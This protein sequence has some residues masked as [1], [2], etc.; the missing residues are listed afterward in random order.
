[1]AVSLILF[2]LAAQAADAITLVLGLPV[3]GIRAEENPLVRA[4]YA[5]G[6]LAAVL[7][8][9]ALLTLNMVVLIAIY[10]G[11]RR[12]RRVLAGIAGGVGLLGA[13]ANLSAIV[14]H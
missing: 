5:N 13:F 11:S 12:R 2:V 10:R 1:M 6:G 9:K 3:V 8:G 4:A 7:A 14:W